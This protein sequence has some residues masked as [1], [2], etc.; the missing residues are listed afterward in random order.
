MKYIIILIWIELILLFSLGCNS[1]REIR[2]KRGDWMENLSGRTYEP[3]DWWS[4]RSPWH[5]NYRT[6]EELQED[7]DETYKEAITDLDKI[8]ADNSDSNVGN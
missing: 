5:R 8:I 7:W 6:M 1:P 3:I 2:E 4:R